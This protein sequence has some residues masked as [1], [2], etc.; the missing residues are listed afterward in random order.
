MK[1]PYFQVGNTQFWVGADR[2]CWHI[3]RKVKSGFKNVT[4]HGSRAQVYA[5][6]VERLIKEGCPRSLEDLIRLEKETRDWLKEE[7]GRE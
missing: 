5:E 6:L 1:V 4:Y 2:Y 3:A 7:L